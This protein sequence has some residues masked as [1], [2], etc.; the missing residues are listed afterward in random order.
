MRRPLA[1]QTACVAAGS[2]S[3][4][5]AL[6]LCP[7]IAGAGERESRSQIITYNIQ[8][9][10]HY[11][12]RECAELTHAHAHTHDD[13]GSTRRPGAR[14]TSTRPRATCVTRSNEATGHPLTT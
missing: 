2:S 9:E 12:G 5:G 1:P 11:S 3:Q 4:R 7:R 13:S 6:C 10:C 14:A 8:E